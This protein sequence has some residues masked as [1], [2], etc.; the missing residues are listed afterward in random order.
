MPAPATSSRAPDPSGGLIAGPVAR[1]AHDH[2]RLGRCVTER[3]ATARGDDRQPVD[4]R[5]LRNHSVFEHGVSRNSQPARWAGATISPRRRRLHRWGPG[6]RPE[7]SASGA[8]WAACSGCTRRSCSRGP[9][10]ARSSR[11]GC[12]CHRRRSWWRPRARPATLRAG[13]DRPQLRLSASS[14]QSAGSGMPSCTR[15]RG[16]PSHNDTSATIPGQI[17]PVPS[18]S[19]DTAMHSGW[20]CRAR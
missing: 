11:S 20:S 6:R 9:R 3:G 19:W 1:G 15:G 17:G 18:P 16:T 2:D 14:K 12:T 4:C 13:R 8:K 5:R 10:S 7:R